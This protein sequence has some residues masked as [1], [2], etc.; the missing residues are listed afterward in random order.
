LSWHVKYQKVVVAP[1]TPKGAADQQ[2]QQ[3]GVAAEE[4][5]YLRG[6]R[7]R[8]RLEVK[9]DDVQAVIPI[10]KVRLNCTGSNPATKKKSAKKVKF[11]Q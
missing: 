11:C 7:L 10:S 1:P 3:E 8:H 6:P 2:Q 5:T 9:K 4:A